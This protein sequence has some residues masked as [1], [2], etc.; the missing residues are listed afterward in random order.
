MQ[1]KFNLSLCVKNKELQATIQEQLTATL[2]NIVGKVITAVN[3]EILSLTKQKKT[4]KNTSVRTSTREHY[5]KSLT[6]PL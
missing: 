1:L 3:K 2:F 4:I 6:T 5:N